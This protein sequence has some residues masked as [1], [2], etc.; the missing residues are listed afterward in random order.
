MADWRAEQSRA[1]NAPA[2]WRSSWR[3]LLLFEA[4]LERNY[5]ATIAVIADEAV[6]AQRAGARG[7]QPWTNGQPDS[8]HRPKRPSARPTL[9]RTPEFAPIE[10]ELS[11]V[12]AKLKS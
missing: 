6:R 5:D 9:W 2:G 3:P 11:G 10:Q 8:S 12:L 1:G 4:G 7:M